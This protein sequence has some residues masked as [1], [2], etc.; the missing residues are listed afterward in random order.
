MIDERSS[1]ADNALPCTMKGLQILLL[2]GF[3][4]NEPH[5]RTQSGFVNS[6][7]IRRIVLGPL[8]EGLHKSRIDQ[9]NPTVIGKKEP[10]P[11]M[12]AGASFH[13]DGFRSEL[14]DRLEQLAAAHLARKDHPIAVNSVTVKRTL[15]EID[16]E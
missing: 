10:A 13:G 1:S 2:D 7:C 6:L 8:Y 9:Q 12:C 14:L 11:K 4:R 5:R 15:A 16:G 3:D